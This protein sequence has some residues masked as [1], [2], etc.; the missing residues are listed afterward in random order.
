MD[1]EAAGADESFKTLD[2]S[3]T[4][5]EEGGGQVE[6]M[7]GGK[8]ISVT[9]SNVHEYARLYAEHRMVTSAKKALQVGSTRF[10]FLSFRIANCS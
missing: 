10:G 9:S 7:K 4:L 6:L 2:L 5:E 3:F 1:A 8:Q